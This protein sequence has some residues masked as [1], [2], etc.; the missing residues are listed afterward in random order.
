MFFSVALK[1]SSESSVSASLATSRNFS[2]WD[3]CRAMAIAETQRIQI[4]KLDAAQRQLR[5]AITLWFRE[6]DPVSAHTLAYAAYTVIDDVTKA[7]NPCRQG[8]LFDSPR[9][10][11]DDRKLFTQVYRRSGNFFKHADRDPNDKLDFSSNLTRGFLS[12]AI[13]GLE[14]AGELLADEMLVFQAWM[15]FNKPELRTQEARKVFSDAFLAKF[16]PDVLPMTKQEFFDFFT[17]VLEAVR[18]NG[19]SST[20]ASHSQVSDS[21]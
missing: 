21:H 11:P 1:R 17:E 20:A 18:S 6:D 5:T 2:T 14:L 7:R 10:T 3:F 13:I 12:F 16:S 15:F 9:L 8:L 19:T 4:S